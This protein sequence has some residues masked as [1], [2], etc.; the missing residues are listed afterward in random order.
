MSAGID[1]VQP[2]LGL[3]PK[4]VQLCNARGVHDASTAE[5]TLTLILTGFFLLVVVGNVEA[6]ATISPTDR[7]AIACHQPIELVERV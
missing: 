7:Y 5:L 6:R 4:G 1:H 2:G 3:L